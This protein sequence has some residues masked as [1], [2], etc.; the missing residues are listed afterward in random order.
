VLEWVEH[1]EL[2]GRW[3]CL[4]EDIGRDFACIELFWLEPAWFDLELTFGSRFNN[5]IEDDDGE[6]EE[7]EERE[8]D[9]RFECITW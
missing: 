3:I 4:D 5:N 8:Q 6:E 9:K 7:D 2:F 1:D